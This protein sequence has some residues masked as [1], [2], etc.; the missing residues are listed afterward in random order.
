MGADSTRREIEHRVW[1]RTFEHGLWDIDIGLLLL[2]FA[3]GIL[4]ELHWI[5]AIIVPVGLPSMRDLAGRAIAVGLRPDGDH[6]LGRAL[7]AVGGLITI[8]G[9]GLLVR[10][11]RRYP[12]HP[13]PTEGGGDG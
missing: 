1:L 10:F 9:V 8:V 2:S 13:E 7:V 5:F 11:I 6:G 4:T 3:M 12:R